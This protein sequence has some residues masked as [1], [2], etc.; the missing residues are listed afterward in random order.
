MLPPG[1]V[2]ADGPYTAAEGAD[3]LAI[4]TE[5]NQFRALDFRRLKEVMKAAVLVDFRNIYKREE[6]TRHG[7]TYASVG[8]P[9]HGRA[10]DMQAA[11]E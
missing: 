4:V 6:V 3:A 9:K 10:G 5:W 8:R 1:V 2:F 11:A 7:F